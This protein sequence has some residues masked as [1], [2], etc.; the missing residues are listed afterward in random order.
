MK[1]EFDLCVA[2]GVRVL[3]VGATG[4]MAKILWDEV[5]SNFASYYPSASPAFRNWFDK[6]GD[7]STGP[8]ELIS[9]IQQ[10][11]EFLQKD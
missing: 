9:S 7:P 5:Q 1:E 11:I 8:S 6:L 2:A 10:S 4:F 3:P